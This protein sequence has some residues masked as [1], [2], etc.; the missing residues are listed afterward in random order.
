MLSN[1][2]T[3]DNIPAKL[4]RREPC[5]NNFLLCSF[6]NGLKR[7]SSPFRFTLNACEKYKLLFLLS[8]NLK[9]G[10]ERGNSY[11][12]KLKDLLMK[13]TQS[14]GSLTETIQTI[15]AFL[16]YKRVNVCEHMVKTAPHDSLYCVFQYIYSP[17]TE[18]DICDRWNVSLKLPC[19]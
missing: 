11:Q 16:N 18:K 1:S 12:K 13:G 4:V 10:Q 6:R 15:D 9:I 7:F 19:V 14:Q 17:L 8:V 2:N 5:H 3:W